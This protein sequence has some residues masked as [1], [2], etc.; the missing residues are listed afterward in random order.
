[1]T[2]THAGYV[3]CDC[4]I[5]EIDEGA[6]TA[7]VCVNSFVDADG[8][9]VEADSCGTIEKLNLHKYSHAAFLEAS[10]GDDV[11]LWIDQQWLESEGI[12]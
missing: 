9:I 7:V 3:D 6:G 4:T 8:N 11:D 12:L 10:E 5:S 1:M 2:R